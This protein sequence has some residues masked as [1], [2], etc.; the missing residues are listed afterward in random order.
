MVLVDN[1][2]HVS[3]TWHASVA[4]VQGAVLRIHIYAYSHRVKLQASSI[5]RLSTARDVV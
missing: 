5:L 2:M 3:Q 4:D 1:G